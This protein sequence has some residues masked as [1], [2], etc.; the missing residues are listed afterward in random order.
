MS[1]GFASVAGCESSALEAEVAAGCG[2]EV[3]ASDAVGSGVVCTGYGASVGGGIDA[4]LIG[5]GPGA[6][7]ANTEAKVR[8]R[9]L[10]SMKAE[11]PMAEI[12]PPRR[13]RRLSTWSGAEPVAS[14][15]AM[16]SFSGGFLG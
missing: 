6:H 9:T 4:T 3:V 8:A 10:R 16:R 5:C 1:L 2:L 7:A 14:A 13:L 11:P 12:G 15:V